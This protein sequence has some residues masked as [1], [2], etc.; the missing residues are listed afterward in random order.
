MTKALIIEAP[1]YA[2]VAALLRS[3]AEAELKKENIA[4]DIISVPGALEIPAALN[5]SLHNKY[6]IYIVLGCIIRGETSHY[7]IVCNESA[8]GIYALVLEHKLALGNAIL[9]VENEAQALKRAD[10]AHK[11]KGRDAVQ[12]ALAINAIKKDGI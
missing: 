2:D 12:A 9:T 4:Y 5:L 6:D 1:Y 7:D 10:P 11:N 3:G 8:R